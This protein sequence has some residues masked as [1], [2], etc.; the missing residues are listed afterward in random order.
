MTLQALVESTP[1]VTASAEWADENPYM[2]QAFDGATHWRVTL[3]FR[4]RRMTVPFSQ[5]SAHTSEPTAANVLG[6]LLSDAIS[7]DESFEEWCD[8][9]GFDTD[10]RKAERTYKVVQAQSEKLKR[11]L[12]D[13]FDRFSQAEW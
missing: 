10:S 5:G 6:C 8:N 2:E 11:L 4:G 13:D 1:K 9:L 7:A 3:R 12:G